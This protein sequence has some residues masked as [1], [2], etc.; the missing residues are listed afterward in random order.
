[1]ESKLVEVSLLEQYVV[2]HSRYEKWLEGKLIMTEMESISLSWF[3]VKEFKLIL[4]NMGF[5]EITVSSDYVFGKEP[6]QSKQV[7]TYEATRK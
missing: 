2:T 5:T 6:S 4:E 1:L 3:G 7:F